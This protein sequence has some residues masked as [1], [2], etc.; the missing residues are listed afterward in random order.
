M[1]EQKD[2]INIKGI[3]VEAPRAVL[4][5]GDFDLHKLNEELAQVEGKDVYLDACRA[6]SCMKLVNPEKFKGVKVPGFWLAE[7]DEQLKRDIGNIFDI[8][9]MDMLPK[10][11]IALKVLY[12][13]ETDNLSDSLKDGFRREIE[14][15]KNDSAYTR[16]MIWLTAAK[17]M[18]PD[19]FSL[20]G[21]SKGNV[22]ETWSQAA[23]PRMDK[24]G[25]ILV[26]QLYVKGLLGGR[27]SLGL[28]YKEINEIA[29]QKTEYDKA[30]P[31]YDCTLYPFA[32]V[33][34]L[35]NADYVFCDSQGIRVGNFDYIDKI[36]DRPEVRRF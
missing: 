26:L 4:S 18:W 31:F 12:G 9:N 25:D 21:A 35:D 3:T 13:A 10:Y 5:I 19:E 16:H 27:M 15:F 29:A 20:D 28:S 8:F 34:A 24:T 22:L 2:R 30:G 36:P 32:A 11:L 23:K 14:Q 6:L 17:I 7:V 1:I 33:I